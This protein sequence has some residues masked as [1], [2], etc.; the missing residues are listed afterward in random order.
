[1]DLLL[2]EAQ[3]IPSHA[4]IALFAIVLGG[5]QFLMTKGTMAHRWLGRIWVSAMLYVAIS[6]FFIHELQVWGDF[7]PIH[8]LSIWTLFSLG[9]AIHLVRTKRIKQH[10]RWMT[11]LYGLALIVTGAF[12]LV[13]GRV[14]HAALF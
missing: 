8:L 13:P 9:Y 4:L 10:Q 11:S 12:T 1:M 7:S 14:M 5:A 2:S 3:P 6:S